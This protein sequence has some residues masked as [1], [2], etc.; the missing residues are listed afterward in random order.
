MQWIKRVVSV[1]ADHPSSISPNT[2]CVGRLEAGLLR[3]V[4]TVCKCSLFFLPI[5]TPL[6]MQNKILTHNFLWYDHNRL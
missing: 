3:I 1:Q 5:P 2:V 6:F 4:G